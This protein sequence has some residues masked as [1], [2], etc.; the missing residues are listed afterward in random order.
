MQLQ[1][2]LIPFLAPENPVPFH[3]FKMK[4]DDSFRPLKKDEYPAELISNYEQELKDIQ[5]LYCNFSETDTN[6]DYTVSVD[7][8]NS[9]L[10]AIHYFR[11][12]LQ[13]YFLS[14]ESVVVSP[15]FINDIEILIPARVQNEVNITLYYCFTLKLQ[16]ARISENF[17]MVISYDGV[18]RQYMKPVSLLGD[19]D[20]KHIQN[21]VLDK[22][23]YNYRSSNSIVNYRLDEAYPIISNTLK[24]KLNL[25]YEYN[26]TENK[27]THTKKLIQGFCQ[28]YIFSEGFGNILK[29]ASKDLYILPSD[30]VKSLPDSSN[31]LLFSDYLNN[32]KIN[33]SPLHG[34]KTIG[35]FKTANIKGNNLKIFF[36][37]QEGTGEKARDYYYDA[38]LNG[39][40][41]ATFKNE[42]GQLINYKKIKPLSK[43]I[44]QHFSTDPNGDITFSSLDT[45]LNEIKTKLNGKNFI[46]GNT[47]L[48]IY[49]SPISKD[50]REDSHYQTVYAGI[51]EL[52]INKG[53]TIQCIYENRYLE[54]S[55][56]YQFTNIQ[57]AILAKIG[58]TPWKL[59][60]TNH[61][62][63][64]IG[65]G[66]FYSTRKNKRYIGSA[67]RFDG[68]GVF[69]EFSCFHESEH[70]TLIAKIRNAL[71]DFIQHNEG[72]PP[73]RIIIHF[74]KKMSKDDWKP[75]LRM[76]KGLNYEIPIIVATIFKTETKDI[77]AFDNNCADL[78]PLS[79]T[80]IEID[81]NTFLLYNNAKHKQESWDKSTDRKIYHF[82]IK[83]KL[84]SRNSVVLKKE[85]IVKD[86]IT[87]IYQLSRMY[88]K[89]V[90][91]QNIPITVKYPEM[92]AEIVPFFQSENIP[93]PQFGC[94][95]LWFL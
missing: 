88:W 18:T 36:I 84:D 54:D 78:M 20:A 19:I 60:T 80:Y 65:V 63:L 24:K 4:K 73:Q 76:L 28:S 12:L 58:G 7:L 5:N 51:K 26:R 53:A 50:S 94:K 45:A 90:D 91:Q 52:I 35:P 17:E 72:N 59:S 39:A 13:K 67:F 62:N 27:Y 29:L 14:L 31:D 61:N 22:Q 71:K 9:T 93:N 33:K 81:H 47:Y 3:F 43:A 40:I 57:A 11:H 44:R 48:A 95:N 37:F 46:N 70:E 42:S 1:F 25:S 79:G 2:N 21:V 82:P 30:K 75:I 64:I 89:S 69:H 41:P 16:Y 34:F 38:L 6:P 10:F 83:V 86:T 56:Q 15:N 85:E 23:T 87:Q 77:V 49:V 32:Q 92:I 68:S 8:N 74:Y 55:L 66:A